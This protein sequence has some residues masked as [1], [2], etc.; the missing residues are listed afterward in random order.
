MGKSVLLAGATGL[1]GSQLL[2]LLLADERIDLVRCV[3]RRP[4]EVKSEKLE[5][6]VAGFDSIGEL[7]E[8]FE[9]DTVFCCL[10]TTMK[11]AGSREAFR[12]VDY[13]YPLSLARH[14]RQAGVERYVLVSAAGA[15]PN[16]RIFYNR[17]KGEVEASIEGLGFPSFDILRPSLLLGNRD[18]SRLGEDLAKAASPLLNLIL[19]GPLRKYRPMP[20][21][22]LAAVMAELPFSPMGG[23]RVFE[24]GQIFE[25]SQTGQPVID[26]T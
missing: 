4:L 20:S 11:K 24:N 19:R 12:K 7:A 13:E 23:K 2:E 18:E 1:V 16:S 5:S 21:S 26:R 25:M 6:V 14:A 8:L 17:T 22:K 10:G 9:V 15:D 3:S